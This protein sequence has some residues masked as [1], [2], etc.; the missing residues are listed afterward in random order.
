MDIERSG[1]ARG[2]M[3]E[4]VLQARAPGI[5]FYVLRDANGLY[6]LDGGFVGGRALLR[7]ALRRSGW[8]DV[9]IRG[10]I[11]THGH[12]DHILNV[13]RIA[14]ETG[15]WVAAPRGDAEHYAGRPR[16]SGWAGATGALEA[17]GRPLLGFEPFTPD[18][19]IE[20]GDRIDVW[21]GLR[22]VH[23]PGHTPGHTGYYCERL[24]LLFSGD[25]FASYRIG[26]RLPP[27]IFN[28]EP[29]RIAA[30]VRAALAL[31]LVGVLPNH[32]DRSSPEV[33]LGRLRTLGGPASGVLR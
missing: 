28:S 18:R 14:R 21:H 9:P 5:N 17:L 2:R 16:Y 10:V 23:L 32:G 22:A 8:S 15:A 30:S 29:Q 25:L 31:D 7:A 19:W 26:P 20:D 3:P 12:L 24:R 6:L 1:P 11:V 33:H 13:G 4:D 27:K